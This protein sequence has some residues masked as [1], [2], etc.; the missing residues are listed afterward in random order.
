M[1]GAR[2]RRQ[3]CSGFATSSGCEGRMSAASARRRRHGCGRLE[4]GGCV[5]HY[6]GHRRYAKLRRGR[7]RTTLEIHWRRDFF[8]VWR[9]VFRGGERPCGT[10]RR[11]FHARTQTEWLRSIACCGPRI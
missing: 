2:L 6:A 1:R 10:M 11:A 8:C 5:I 3:D 7:V 9:G 4:C